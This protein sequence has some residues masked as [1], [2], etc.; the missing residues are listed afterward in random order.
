LEIPI[1]ISIIIPFNSPEDGLNR[2]LQSISQEDYPTLELVLVQ[3]GDLSSLPS[4]P[5]SLTCLQLSITDRNWLQAVEAGVRKASGNLIAIFQPGTQLNPGCLKEVASAFYK[6][7]DLNVLVGRTRCFDSEGNEL[8]LEHPGSF[9]SHVCLLQIWRNDPPPI[10]AVYAR[11]SVFR[12]LDYLQRVFS[13]KWNGYNILC[14]ISQNENIVPVKTFVAEYSLLPDD[15]LLTRAQEINEAVQISRQYWGSTRSAI[16]WLVKLAF[17]DN[18]M[19]RKGRAQTLLHEANRRSKQSKRF[20][21]IMNF[22]E[23]SFLAPEV[24]FTTSVFPLFRDHFLRKIFKL[25]PV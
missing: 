25:F 5:Q 15:I 11:T 18:K 6:S 7:P 23:A 16:Y 19:N 2:T 17:L 24:V 3:M 14:M 1:T 12:R 20:S 22:L 21:A 10:C 13:E 9:R 8:G 4:I